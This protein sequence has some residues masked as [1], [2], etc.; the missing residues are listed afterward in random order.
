MT[1][2][3]FPSDLKKCGFLRNFWKE[4]SRKC[5]SFKNVC[6]FSTPSSSSYY[7]KKG[8]SRPIKS[9]LL[10]SYLYTV[11]Q[12][13]LIEFDLLAA[14]P[15]KFKFGGKIHIFRALTKIIPILAKIQN[16]TRNENE[17]YLDIFFKSKIL[18]Y[19]SNCLNS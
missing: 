6:Q 9:S 16:W 13:W 4:K 18:R 12:Y 19:S 8:I 15:H 7:K 14:C 1:T 2:W 17:D 5:S 10:S 3:T 11:H